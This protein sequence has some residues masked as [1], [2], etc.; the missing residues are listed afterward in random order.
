MKIGQSLTR[1]G[2][3][4]AVASHRSPFGSGL[5]HLNGISPPGA[6]RLIG[7]IG[8]MLASRGLR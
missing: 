4:P 6:A 1:G 3:W 2:W 5:Q 7:D 8:N